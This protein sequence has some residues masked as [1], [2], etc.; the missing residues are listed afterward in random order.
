MPRLRWKSPH[1]SEIRPV[2]ASAEMEKSALVGNS[3]PPRRGEQEKRTNQRLPTGESCAPRATA[4][5]H[6]SNHALTPSTLPSAY[7]SSARE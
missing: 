1:R 3:T 2:D 7:A 4:A 5:A 6:R